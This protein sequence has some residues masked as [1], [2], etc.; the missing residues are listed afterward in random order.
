MLHLTWSLSKAPY[1]RWVDM[2][3]I[4]L[5][6][7]VLLQGPPQLPHQDVDMEEAAAAQH[8]P[9]AVAAAAGPLQVR[10]GPSHST[11][12]LCAR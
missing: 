10:G 6:V 4:N 8:P 12:K 5:C 2:G 11:W 3:T 9:A 7:Y 1:Q